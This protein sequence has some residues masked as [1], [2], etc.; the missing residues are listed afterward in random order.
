MSEKSKNYSGNDAPI[1]RYGHHLLTEMQER[2]NDNNREI[3]KTRYNLI[4]TV[5]FE[6][7]SSP[8]KCRMGTKGEVCPN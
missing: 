6:R 4:V 2:K 7:V 8:K 5:P 3:A 1:D